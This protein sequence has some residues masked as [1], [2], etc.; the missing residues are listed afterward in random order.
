MTTSQ[1][2]RLDRIEQMLEGLIRIQS[3]QQH[4]IES[5]I[6]AQQNQQSALERLIDGQLGLQAQM[7]VLSEA[8]LDTREETRQLKRAV[9]YLLS[10]DGETGQRG[11]SDAL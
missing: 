9:D 8:M 2:D 6:Q 5:V 1:P 11:N 4:S 3:T 10:R 7:G